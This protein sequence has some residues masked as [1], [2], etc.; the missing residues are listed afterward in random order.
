MTPLM[1]LWMPIVVSAIAVWLLSSVIHMAMPWHRNDY[2]KVPDEDGLM[3]AMRPFGLAPGEYM[4]PRPRSGADM[5]SP[6]YLAKV[7]KGPVAIMTIRPGT[8][9][10]GRTMATWFVFA[11]LVA[12]TAA[13]MTGAV[14]APGV[15]HRH[16]IHYA[17]AI[18]FLCYAMGGVSQSIW[19]GRKWSTTFKH[20]FDA[21]IYGVATGLIF[22]AFWPQM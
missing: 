6:E 19:Y 17:G 14:M 2:V 5:K 11:L 7:A 1:S 12:V 22:A 4:M 21:L 13:C 15:D 10:M 16:V 9:N 20:A 3:A 8:W 18:T